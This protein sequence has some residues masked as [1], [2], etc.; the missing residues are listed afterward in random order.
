[1]EMRACV[2]LLSKVLVGLC[3]ITLKRIYLDN[4]AEYQSWTI[5][6]MVKCFAFLDDD[7]FGFEPFLF[8]CDGD[9]AR[10]G[11]LL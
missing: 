8:F 1:M 5:G 2:M 10:K 7:S 3:P 6:G 4:I 11:I 9:S